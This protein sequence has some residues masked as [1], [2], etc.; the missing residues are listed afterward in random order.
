L[1][2]V[3]DDVVVEL[4]RG[5]RV[6][7]DESCALNHE[8][9]RRLPG[10]DVRVP[11]TMASL[12][13]DRGD[14]DLSAG[15]DDDARD[16]WF[17]HDLALDVED[18][19]TTLVCD[20]L[21][22]IAEV[23]LDGELLLRSENM[24]RRHAIDVTGRIK[25]G[26]SVAIRFCSLTRH[27]AVRRPRPRWKTRMVEAQQLRFV[28]TSWLG[29][30]TGFSPNLPP[31][32]PYRS[33]RLVQH[34]SV[35]VVD[36]H[37]QASLADHDGV[38]DIRCRLRVHGQRALS[39]VA[40]TVVG[41]SGEAR[42]AVAQ[43][44][45]ADR[46]ILLTCQ[47]RVPRVELW[48][49]HTHGKQPRYTVGLD[50]VFS[51]QT[52]A[53]VE[54]G[55]VGFRTI[56]V[57]RTDDRFQLSVNG[58]PLFVRGACWTSDD[59]VS[60][61]APVERLRASIDLARASG[62]NMLRVGGTS[63]YESDA[64]YEACDAVGILVFQDFMFANMDFPAADPAFVA[65]V[66]A[67]ADDVL[68]RIA[69]RP[70][71]AV[72]CGGSEIE[73]Q[74]AMMG[75]APDAWLNTIFTETLPAA[76]A[77]W[78]PAVAYVASTPSGGFLP[79]QTNAGL[80]HYYGVGAYLRALG[81]ERH[82]A[83]R[84]ATE[85]LAFANVPERE[86]IDS[87]MRDLD[88][89]AHHPRWKERVPRDRGVGWDFEDVRDH[90]V[91]A[92]FNVDPM[93]LRYS[94]MNR[95]L[96]LG[97]VV[98][99]ELMARVFSE[100]RRAESTCAGGLVWTFQDL[101]DGAGWGLVDAR[102]VPKSALYMLAPVLQPIALLVADERASGLFFHAINDTPAAIAGTLS[103]TFYR[104]GETVAIDASRAVIVPARG[105]LRVHADEVVGRFVDSTY[106]Y[107]FGPPA[108]DVVVAC[109]RDSGGQRLAQAFYLPL[110]LDRPRERDLGLD[111]EWRSDGDA[112][113]VSVRSR[114]F[115][116]YVAIDVD[117]YRP[118][119]N[120]F[121]I[122]P[123]GTRDIL[124]VPTERGVSGNVRGEI[125]ALNALTPVRIGPASARRSTPGQRD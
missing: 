114:S 75:V 68:E 3:S 18:V 19:P 80:S 93:R 15:R 112:I 9:V 10:I 90:Y 34:H 42:S 122:E 64:F 78:C 8:Q 29:R 45:L 87:F 35:R 96:A 21:A 55:A 111:A 116:Q 16:C 79:F 106:S 117:G 98:T 27:L 53:R 92:L 25:R 48:W 5:W 81:D 30:T 65:E 124:L 1:R 71:L 110:G 26:S 102:G 97:R 88:A 67:E 77:C 119:D 94:D 120:Y 24:F 100:W 59:V 11:C 36:T 46:D 89:P 101:W 118:V 115:A 28:R 60:L 91:A 105:Q 95:Y 99:G 83:V 107:R 56:D 70:S 74:A 37:V 82:A 72:L 33:V 108:H 31:V 49:P 76:V 12:A 69:R 17:I 41:A 104:D 4:D 73:Q 113:V 109:L 39:V 43:V 23:Y 125:T 38:V 20:G 40:A 57:D 66:R 51:D 121:H 7:V 6:V 103:I 22:T 58:V 32:G 14:L 13:R 61:N 123:A 44:D 2:H 52:T 47:V 62:M 63:A 86:T 85:C 84:F 54:L 50:L